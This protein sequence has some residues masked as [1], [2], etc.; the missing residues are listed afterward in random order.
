MVDIASDSR[1]A[2]CVHFYDAKCTFGFMWK[3][4]KFDAFKYLSFGAFVDTKCS[5]AVL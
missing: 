1:T 2:V 4:V 5:N 3:S